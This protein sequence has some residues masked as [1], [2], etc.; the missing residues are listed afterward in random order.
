[1]FKPTR[2][3]AIEEQICTSDYFV[4]DLLL[5][6]GSIAEGFRSRS[7]FERGFS[8]PIAQFYRGTSL[9]KKRPPLQDHYRALDRPTVGSQG[10]AVSY[11]RGT[12]VTLS[13]PARFPSGV[14]LKLQAYFA[15]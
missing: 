11:D 12:P 14:T 2:H 10:V 1:M 4:V 15:H 9:L 13:F 5:D 8:G 7:F 3:S 6:R